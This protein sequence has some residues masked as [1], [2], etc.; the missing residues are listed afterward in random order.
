MYDTR[1][2]C[3]LTALLVCSPRPEPGTAA[4]WESGRVVFSFV[5]CFPVLPTFAPVAAL[6]ASH[7][8]P[9]PR[10][11]Q[12]LSN[13]YQGSFAPVAHV[14]KATDVAHL[15]PSPGW[16]RREGRASALL[17]DSA[18]WYAERGLCSTRSLHLLRAP[19]G[20]C[21]VW[22]AL[23]QRRNCWNRWRP[24]CSSARA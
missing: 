9:C 20:T 15:C 1:G 24:V 5:S 23:A 21:C 4:V 11:R 7:A 17:E 3:C 8:S 2:L 22:A 10:R 12:S 18:Q 14:R 19:A 6:A 16:A 13:V